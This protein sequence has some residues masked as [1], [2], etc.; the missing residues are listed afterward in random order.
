MIV[1]KNINPDRDIYKLGAI[2]ID[3]IGKNKL[4]AF[5][6]LETYDEVCKIEN[7]SL[8][9]YLFT[10]DWLFILGVIMRKPNGSLEKC[11]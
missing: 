7:V 6:L 8:Q 9:L 3:I 11:F 2:V 10:L 4:H 1:N 5:G